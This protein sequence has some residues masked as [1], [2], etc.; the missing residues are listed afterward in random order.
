MKQ[1]TKGA[2]GAPFVIV[3]RRCH[4]CRVE[5]APNRRPGTDSISGIPISGCERDRAL[6]A[7]GQDFRAGRGRGSTVACAM[8]TIESATRKP[9]A[10]TG[11]GRRLVRVRQAKIS[12]GRFPLR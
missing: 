8:R 3:C 6:S 12:K 2:V 7:R 5:L 11:S 9:P 1:I 10:G 4:G